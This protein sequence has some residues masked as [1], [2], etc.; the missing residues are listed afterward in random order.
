MGLSYLVYYY[1]ISYNPNLLGDPE[2][3]I[4][5]N[6]L[7]TSIHIRMVSFVCLCHI[8]SYT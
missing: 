7:V 2:N 5:A 3:F 8:K 1:F 4:N 6:P